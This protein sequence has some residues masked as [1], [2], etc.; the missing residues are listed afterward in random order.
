[1]RD[2]LDFSL[3]PEAVRDACREAVAKATSRLDAL[4]AAPTGEACQ[5]RGVCEALDAV[6]GDLEAETA[7][8]TFLKYCSPDAAVREAA[9]AAETE[10]GRYSV[11]VF[12]RED[13]YLR[14][15]ASRA[16]GLSPAAARLREKTLSDFRRNG[17]DLPPLQRARLTLWRKQLLDM[18]LAFGKNLNEV[19]DFLAA[20]PSDLEGLPEEFVG[21]LGVLPDG[22]RKVTLD[23]P[24]S[25]PFMANAR[26]PE[27]RRAMYSLVNRRAVPENVALLEE[28]LA[29]RRRVAQA[30][31]YPSYAHYILEERMARTP[32]AVSDFLARLRRRLADKAAPER[33][34]LLA[35]KRSEVP[36]AERLE[37]WDVAYY[38]NK[39]KKTAYDL[40]EFEIAG[41][42][43]AEKVVAGVME[44]YAGLF[45]VRFAPSDARA[46][47]PDVR[48]FDCVDAA[49]G[50]PLGRVYLDLFP[51]EGKF[52][53]AAV[54]P[55]VRGRREAD[56]A[57]RRPSAAML[58]NFPAPAGGRPGLLKHSEVETFFHEF[59][60]VAHNLLTESPFSRF[61]G[62]RVARDFVEAPSQIM[63]NWAW[64]PAVL[65]KVS[66]HWKTG[67]PLPEALIERMLEAKHLN[68]GIFTLRQ[69]AM[70]V[71]DQALHAPGKAEP[72]ETFARIHEEVTTFP[73]AEGNRP[74]ASFGHL[75]SY[76]AS[77]YG[78]LWSDVYSADMFSVFAA[79]GD[80]RSP[81][82]GGRYR[83][84]VLAP[85]GTR[86]EADL[87]RDFL[88]REP[89]E[90]A[91]LKNLGLAPSTT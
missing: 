7:A 47:H 25:L 20:G 84:Q 13:L 67:E 26:R 10:L 79:S 82:A 72:G 48:V 54:F 81:E 58:C 55:L 70:A 24:D 68:S 28:I 17:L 1:M 65:R 3:S 34:R 61:A 46:W 27:A 44:L 36:G 56:G 14:A 51:R 41:Y 52:K 39:L 69:L 42:F 9:H 21:R 15:K 18:E 59:G 57:Y 66:G 16:E 30:L 71:I 62:T 73:V 8:P 64:A 29:L 87:V 77:Y 76:A 38:H 91:F 37:I 50:R 86:E 49:D 11:D 33:E 75:M 74:E 31:G 4:A 60:H 88:G 32:E 78:Y 43:P 6:L 53:H 89:S 90:D 45:G 80:L 23:Y 83:R 63:E 22:R 2:W 12:T 85:G 19:R 40:D 35:L 5:V